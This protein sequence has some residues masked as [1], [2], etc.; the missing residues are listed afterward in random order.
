MTTAHCIRF[1]LAISPDEYLA[2][3]EGAA[4]EVVARAEDGRRVRFPAGAL[5]RFVGHQ[6]IHGFFELEFDADRK[7]LGLRRLGD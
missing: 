5:Q 2:F 3:Y 1:R 4:R 7:L 6:G